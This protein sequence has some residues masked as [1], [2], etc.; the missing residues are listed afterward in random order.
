MTAAAHQVFGALAYL[1]PLVGT[2]SFIIIIFAA[3][4]FETLFHHIHEATDETPYHD[5][6]HAIQKELMIVGFIAFT[7]KLI[8]NTSTVLSGPWLLGIE[9]ADITIPFTTA[10]YCFIGVLLILLSYGHTK[11][12]RRAYNMHLAEILRNF[13]ADSNSRIEK[14]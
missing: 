9:F 14:M 7:F 8:A 5:M 1:D 11:Q 13:Y 10:I 2:L 3:W 12:W 4:T 6:L